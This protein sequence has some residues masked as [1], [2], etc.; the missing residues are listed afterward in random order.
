MHSG[1]Q[2]EATVADHLP[3]PTTERFYSLPPIATLGDEPESISLPQ[4][5]QY[6]KEEPSAQPPQLSIQIPSDS[7]REEGEIITPSVPSPRPPLAA[8]I[9]M[10]EVAP[11]SPTVIPLSVHPTIQSPPSPSMETS[12][13]ES[14]PLSQPS[15][16]V[17]TP[18]PVAKTEFLA[19]VSLFGPELTVLGYFVGKKELALHW[20]KLLFEI[21][22]DL[23]TRLTCWTRRHQHKE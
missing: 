9:K 8:D 22:G 16:H 18:T 6:L 1:P 2:Q 12:I 17:T 15:S 11:P 4:Q 5:Q 7:Q 20:V 10:G 3:D 21:N 13:P 23:F 14:R 19:D